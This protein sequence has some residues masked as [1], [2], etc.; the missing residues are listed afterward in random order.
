[1]LSQGSNPQAVQP[2]LQSV[3]DSVVRVEFDAANASRIV[4]LFSPQGE[5]VE[6]EKPVDAVGNIEEW[7][8]K[9]LKAMQGS[10]NAQ[11]RAASA[12]CEQM[13]LADFTHKYQAQV[14]L[15]GIQFKWTL[16]CEDALYQAKTVKGVM[17]ATNKKNQQRLDDLVALNLLPDEDLLQHGKWSRTKIETMILVD[18]HQRDVF[19]DMIKAKIKDADHFE[20]QKQARFYF[21]HDKDVALIAVADVDF[22]YCN[23]YLGVKERLV[24]TPLTDRCYIALSQ[25]LGMC[26]GGAPAGPAGTGKTETTKDMGNTLGKYTVVFNCGDQMDYRIMGAIY[27]GLSQSGC[28]GCF[29]E[30]N[31]I[32]LEV[33]SVVAQQVSSVLNAIKGGKASF[34]F[35]DGHTISL[36]AEVGFFI[37]MNP[38]YAGRQELPEN[39][40][41]LFRGVMMSKPLPIRKLGS[42][43]LLLHSCLTF[44][45]RILVRQWCPIVRS[46]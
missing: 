43:P 38:G 26:L 3:F 8:Y 15:I 18:V 45:L 13:A 40:K 28:W 36:D 2:H 7:L 10:V 22:D 5:R 21:Q 4:T 34:Q 35:T 20:W 12:D 29:D 32:D 17:N 11:V 37:T 24:I 25:A 6:L 14:S 1:V 9:L 31:R 33:L 27:K 16:D 46:S 39:L 19:A 23:E 41:S 30:F 42:S 44:R